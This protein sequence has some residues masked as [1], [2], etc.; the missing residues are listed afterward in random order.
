MCFSHPIEVPVPLAPVPPGA[1]DGTMDA[2]TFEAP[3]LG[4]PVTSKLIRNDENWGVTVEWE[5]HGVL[6]AFLDGEFHLRVYYDS[7]G[8]GADGM[9]PPLPAGDVLVNALSGVLTFP[10]GVPT[11]NYTQNIA[12]L[13]GGVPAGT[14]KLVVLLQLWSC[15]PT[16]HKYPIAGMV[17]L[18]VIDI[19]EPGP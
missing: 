5:M 9:L 18:R 15:C 11:R 8:P 7:I 6:A 16:P 13:P 19:F 3:E 12:V 14:Y 17:E 10:A 4:L 2:H 1:Y